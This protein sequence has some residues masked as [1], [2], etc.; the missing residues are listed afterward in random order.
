MAS[1]TIKKKAAF[2]SIL[3]KN[4]SVVDEGTCSLFYDPNTQTVRL[5]G[6]AR[7]TGATFGTTAE[8][9]TVPSGY[10]PKYDNHISARGFPIAM[11]VS[12]SNGTLFPATGWVNYDG[13]ITQ[14]GSG[15]AT[16]VYFCCE[17]P[18]E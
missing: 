6:S 17:Y 8:L 3:E 11:L 16:S 1:G 18:C 7:S 10:R 15:Y 4:E 5:Y 2:F 12:G 14:V 9:Y 13:T